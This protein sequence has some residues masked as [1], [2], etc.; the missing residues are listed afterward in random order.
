MLIEGLFSYLAADTGL[1]EQLGTT[2]TR[3]DHTTGIF[4]TVAPE[5]VP[6][7]YVVCQQVAGEPLQTSFQ[8]IGRLQTARWRFSTYGSSY[9]Q[10]KKVA[11]SLRLALL[12]MN[13]VLVEGDVCIQGSWLEL[14]ADDSEPIPHGNIYSTHL[15]FNINFQDNVAA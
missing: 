13:G 8:G 6:V 9:L 7:P 10:A 15:D 11:E 12:G 4:P 14:E 5:S 2:S 3:R 1:A